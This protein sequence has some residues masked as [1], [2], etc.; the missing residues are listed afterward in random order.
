M[1]GSHSAGCEAGDPGWGPLSAGT[2][3]HVQA[4]SKVR[5]SGGRGERGERRE[6]REGGESRGREGSV[7]NLGVGW[8]VYRGRRRRGRWVWKRRKKMLQLHRIP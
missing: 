7:G 4:G 3:H 6:E 5:R 2:C 8:E 1:H